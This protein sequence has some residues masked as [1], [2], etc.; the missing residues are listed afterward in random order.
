MIA[1]E[2]IAIAVASGFV[3]GQLISCCSVVLLSNDANLLPSTSLLSMFICF[4]CDEEMLWVC[5]FD[6]CVG[7]NPSTSTA[8]KPSDR[9]EATADMANFILIF[10]CEY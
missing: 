4:I 3:S 5:I 10:L 2:K 1:R 7:A 8:I 9:I 6:G